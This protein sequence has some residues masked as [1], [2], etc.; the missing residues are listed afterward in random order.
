VGPAY[1]RP[2]H[3]T[4]LDFFAFCEDD[5]SMHVISKRLLRKFWL[6]HPDAER[7]LRRW[8]KTAT[9]ATWDSFAEVRS[10][11]AQA[12]QVGKFTVFNVGGNKYRLITRIFYATGDFRGHAYVLHVL[13]HKGYDGGK[14]KVD[15]DCE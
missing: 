6:L 7:P 12:D 4:R 15:C 1:A 13:T 10:T 8:Y 3:P 2:R 11:Y 9:E 14:W 5:D